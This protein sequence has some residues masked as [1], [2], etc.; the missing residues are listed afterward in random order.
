MKYHPTADIQSKNIGINT[1]I[2]QYVIILPD[3]VI[4]DNCSI[5]AFCFIENDV[6]IGD[7]ITIKNGVSIWDGIRIENNAFIGPYVTFINDKFPRSKVYPD[8]FFGAYIE[9]GASI[10]ANATIMSKIRIGSY[11]MIGAGSV[12][13]KDIPNNTIWVGNPARQVGYICDCGHPLNDLL[14]CSN[15]NSDY[16]L[17]KNRIIKK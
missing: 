12:V 1:I 4:G 7:N 6:I 14:H 16:K 11:A 2:W 10:G 9:K 5:D 3:A 13:T 8:K 15:C 17:E